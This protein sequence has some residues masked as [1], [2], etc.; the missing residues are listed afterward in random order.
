[1]KLETGT[2]KRTKI[3]TLEIEKNRNC[4]NTRDYSIWI[5][6]VWILVIKTVQ[7]T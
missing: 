3:E 2:G 7:E 5:P 1:M 6:R 4:I